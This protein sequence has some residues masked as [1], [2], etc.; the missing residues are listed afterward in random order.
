MSSKQLG[1]MFEGDSV[2]MC[3]KNN[4]VYI[5]GGLSGGSCVHRPRNEDP[6]VYREI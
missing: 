1:D 2:D 3:T 4:S 6:S 5:D